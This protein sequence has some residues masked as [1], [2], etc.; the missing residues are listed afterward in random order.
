MIKLKDLAERLGLSP[1]TVSRA[2][3]GYPE[4][5]EKT[6][7]RVLEVARQFD[8]RPNASA[9]RL[10]TGRAGAI[11]AV[12]PTNRNLLV[13]PHFVEFLA[14]IGE[15]LVEDEID[16]VL[17]PTTGDDEMASYRRMA[18]GTRVDAIILSSPMVD[19]PRVPLLLKLG[20]PFV[21]HGRTGEKAA[22]HA[23]LDID[24]EGGFRHAT[25]HLLDLGHE[26]IGLINGELRFTYA[27]YREG[28]Y[29]EA[30]RSRGIEADP[31]L[32]ANGTMTDEFGYRAT[33]RFL[34]EQPP[35]TAIVVGS[36]MLALGAFRALRSA[37]LELGKD[38]SI[39]AHDDVFPFLNADR[40]VPPMSTT[41]SSI[42]SAG[43]RV[44]EIAIDL[45]TGHPPARLQELWPVDLVI[46]GS[47]GPAPGR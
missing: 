24:N 3:N 28:G 10:A 34:A 30:L 22:A 46:R 6:R 26:R 45:L 7:Q 11:G 1:T 37:G 18:A 23:W 31:R 40:M 29:R 39:I 17:S 4:V 44:A 35:P 19:D 47:T 41:R 27:I 15:R 36:M 43:T 21:I 32:M 13:D 5:N 2:L 38:V 8:Y 14:G 42:R 20:F 12:L 25:N 33:Q 9:R 16:I